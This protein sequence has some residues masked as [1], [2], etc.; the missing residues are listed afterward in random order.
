MLLL[1][2]TMY[3]T[4]LNL[5]NKSQKTKM[6]IS[7][8]ILTFAAGFSVLPFYFIY[9]IINNLADSITDLSSYLVII[10]FILISYFFAYV[11]LFLGYHVSHILAY[12]V[13]YDVRSDLADRMIRFP[14]G[15][16]IDTNTGDLQ[17]TLDENVE[18]L[19]LFLAHHFPEM[20]SLIIV[21]VA[22]V[23]LTIIINPGLGELIAV[24]L[25]ISLLIVIYARRDFAPAIR[26][27]IEN[28]ARM[29]AAILEHLQGIKV[30]RTFSH[31][32]AN[33]SAFR[34]EM[35]RYRDSSVAWNMKMAPPF[36]VYQAIITSMLMVI[37]PAGGWM[38]LSGGITAGEFFFFLITGT[39]FGRLLLR[40]YSILRY[41]NE[42]FECMERI[43]KIKAV[44]ALPSPDI[45]KKPDT[46]SVVFEKVNF[47][48][49]R[50]QVLGDLSFE[51][52]EGSTT[53]IVGP[54][55]AGKT[56]IAR[57]VPRFYDPTGGRVLIG[58]VDI[59][60]IRDSDLTSLISVV[61]QEVYL[62]HDTILEN[63]RIGRPDATDDAVIAAARAARCDT[64]IDNLPDGYDTI[65][66]DRGLR[67]SGGERQRI[68][69]A[70]SLLK[71]APILILDEATAFVDPE[72]E[73][74]IQEAL[75]TL[76]RGKT[77]IVIAHRLNTIRTVDQILYLDEGKIVER[78]SFQSLMDSKGAF[79]AMW[80]KFEK[81]CLWKIGGV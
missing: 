49:S 11:L 21:P 73:A 18:K 42:E 19:E 23:I 1:N 45:E 52:P 10:G 44:P 40:I 14:L 54:S 55:G 67:L 24:T 41:L 38:F 76:T 39:L 63:I 78:G 5:M 25:L 13:L 71:D 32:H 2:I 30:I 74:L 66:G 4:I 43:N 16:F 3:L 28:Q 79:T 77:I 80:S 33:K 7:C 53:A 72:N 20:V 37:V 27:V 81:T 62:F 46:F 64:F 57:L 58:G 34:R 69:I 9:V 35:G 68:S 61:F 56:T 60:D 15:F 36:S 51:V 70:R 17:V 6:L 29:H 65:V 31:A 75:T 8:L 59:R 26:K 50:L 22:L 48:Y 47:S 12:E